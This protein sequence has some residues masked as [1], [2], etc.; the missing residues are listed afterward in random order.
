MAVLSARAARISFFHSPLVRLLVARFAMLVIQLFVISFLTFSLIS[1]APGNPV[2][3]YVGNQ[4]TTPQI[5]AT[6]TNRYHLNDPFIV[7]YGLWLRSALHFNFGNSIQ[8]GQPVI[9]MVAE[10]LPVTLFLGIYAF[11]IGVVAGIMLGT[12]S[13][14]RR[15]GVLDRIV[16]G[17]STVGISAPAF[18]SGL[19]VLYIFALKFGWFPA[20]GAGEGFLNRVWHMTLPALT[21]AATTSALVLRL[22]RSSMSVVLS[23]DYVTFARARGVRPRRVVVRYALTN[24]M[25]PIITALGLMLAYVLTGAVIIET[26][27]DLPGIGSLLIESVQSEDIPVVQALAALTCG[28][29]IV[30]NMIVDMAY[31]LLDPQ[32]RSG[33]DL[34]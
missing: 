5:I 8:S 26:V 19:L 1:L 34:R 20:S 11:V 30:I 29:V 18:V 24:A 17:L 6:L 28:T 33:G 23:Q 31:L 21:L 13:A 10:R 9:Q 12:F 27:Y 14:L 7:Q 22:T 25:G 16:V 32:L 2:L 3:T 15:G 4:P